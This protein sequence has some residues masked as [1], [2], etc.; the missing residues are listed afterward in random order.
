VLTFISWHSAGIFR[1]PKIY[2]NFAEAR[3]RA[4]FLPAGER[5]GD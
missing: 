1:L 4:G 5:L 2:P 3:R